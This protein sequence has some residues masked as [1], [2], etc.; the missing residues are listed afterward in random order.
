MPSYH[1]VN[2]KFNNQI[3]FSKVLNAILIESFSLIFC[4]FVRLIPHV[5]FKIIESTI[6]SSLKQTFYSFGRK[7]KCLVRNSVSIVLPVYAYYF[8]YL[9]SSFK[10]VLESPW[11]QKL[12][13]EICSPIQEIGD[14]VPLRSL[15]SPLSCQH[16]QILTRARSPLDTSYL[17]KL[18]RYSC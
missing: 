2:S 17:K 14:K 5:L 9:K 15:I 18:Y 4:G 10:Y 1:L 7:I 6:V 8:I 13:M 11:F 3:S 12:T 16:N